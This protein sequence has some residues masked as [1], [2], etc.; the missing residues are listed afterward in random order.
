MKKTHVLLIAMGIFQGVFLHKTVVGDIDVAI[1]QGC[2][3][4]G[5]VKKKMY[6]PRG[7]ETDNSTGNGLSIYNKSDNTA[8]FSVQNSSIQAQGTLG[9][10]F[11]IVTGA[12]LVLQVP[13]GELANV[14]LDVS[15]TTNFKVLRSCNLDDRPCSLA[16]SNTT[17][18]YT[19]TKGKT[20]YV[21]WNPG[22]PKNGHKLYPQTG[23]SLGGLF[24]FGITDMCYDTSSN[25]DQTDIRQKYPLPER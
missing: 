13:S 12:E 16:K 11:N 19:F 18:E 8:Y 20:I 21:T 3:S 24:K 2:I 1:G 9:R 25:V 6:H 5:S 4:F 14:P 22:K 15:K 7:R 23:P 17:A 10:A